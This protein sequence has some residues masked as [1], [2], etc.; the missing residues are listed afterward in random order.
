MRVLNVY[1]FPTGGRKS[2]VGIVS[3]QYYA[4][5]KSCPTIVHC[6][7]RT[8]L[9][10]KLDCIN[11]AKRLYSACHANVENGIQFA[12]SNTNGSVTTADLRRH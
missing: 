7:G 3:P 8:G 1:Y 2:E 4:R 10:L 12:K 11:E 6:T 5:S 9:K